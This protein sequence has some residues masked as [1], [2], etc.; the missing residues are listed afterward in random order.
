MKGLFFPVL[1]KNVDHIEKY[2]SSASKTI[3]KFQMR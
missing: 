1:A 2:S 3:V